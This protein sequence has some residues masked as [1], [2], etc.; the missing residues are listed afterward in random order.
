M[1]LYCYGMR[2]RGFSPMC[3]PKGVYTHEEDRTGEYYDKLWY[4][5]K[6]TEKE[7]SDYDLDYIGDGDFFHITF[8]KEM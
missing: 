3:Q 4:E 8:K 2:L 7:M 6:L 5:R 1:H